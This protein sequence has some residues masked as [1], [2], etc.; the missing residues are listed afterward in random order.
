LGEEKVRV[1]PLEEEVAVIKE[2]IDVEAVEEEEEEE[3]E[4]EVEEEEVEDFCGI[5]R[6]AASRAKASRA[7][8]RAFAY[9]T[10]QD[11]RGA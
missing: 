1:G 9:K 4:I 11:M 5:L 3:P 10:N 7:T 2:E 6:R 8:S